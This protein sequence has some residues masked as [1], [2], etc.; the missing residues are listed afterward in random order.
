MGF[1]GGR[2]ERFG[3]AVQAG[4]FDGGGG[5]VAHGAEKGQKVGGEPGQPENA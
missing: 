2:L 5:G 1:Q 4:L 3:Q